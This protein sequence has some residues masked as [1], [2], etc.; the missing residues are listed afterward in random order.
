M[1]PWKLNG[2][3]GDQ[4]A[5][6][7]VHHGHSDPSLDGSHFRPW[8]CL[9]ARMV[10]SA[11]SYFYGPVGS[12]RCMACAERALPQFHCW[13]AGDTSLR[14]VRP[15]S[16]L[17]LASRDTRAFA[18]FPFKSKQDGESS[19]KAAAALRHHVDLRAAQYAARRSALPPVFHLEQPASYRTQTSCSNTLEPINFSAPNQFRLTAG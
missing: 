10:C 17:A 15:W 6:L 14:P 8:S 16:F 19:R 12:Y 2:K 5:F 18:A 13:R 1:D 7:R 4:P 9:V 3:A 11:R